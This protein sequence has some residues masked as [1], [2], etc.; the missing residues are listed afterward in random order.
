MQGE[1]VVIYGEPHLR[2]DEVLA[3]FDVSEI[4]FER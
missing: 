2:S 1:A 3:D 4:Y